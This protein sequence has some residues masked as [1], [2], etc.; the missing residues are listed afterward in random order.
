M[1][2]IILRPALRHLERRF[3][4][5]IELNEDKR[6]FFTIYFCKTHTK[7]WWRWRTAWCKM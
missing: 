6:Q 3:V 4:G 2:Q 1:T 7:W 5:V